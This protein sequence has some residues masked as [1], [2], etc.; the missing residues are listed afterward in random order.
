MQG[1]KQLCLKLGIQEAM[2]EHKRHM[3]KVASPQLPT[4]VLRAQIFALG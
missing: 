3:K 2:E 1:D 4:G